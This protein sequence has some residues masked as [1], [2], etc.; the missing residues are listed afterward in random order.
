MRYEKSLTKSAQDSITY[1][2]KRIRDKSW[3]TTGFWYRFMEKNEIWN[4]SEEELLEDFFKY[5]R[6]LIVIIH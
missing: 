6:I 3:G 5:E 1:L 4:G 2:E